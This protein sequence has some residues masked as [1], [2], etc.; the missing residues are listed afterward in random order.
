MKST[1]CNSKVTA[2]GN[3]TKF[4]VC[5][6][7]KKPCDA[8]ESYTLTTGFPYYKTVGHFWWKKE[9]PDGWEDRGE[10]EKERIGN[11]NYR[12]ACNF[13]NTTAHIGR[14]NQEAFKFCPRCLVKIK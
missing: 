6:E 1:C 2:K 7:C 13:C 10:Q 12:Y 4:F 14:E 8:T 9:V 5:N 3:T 11:K